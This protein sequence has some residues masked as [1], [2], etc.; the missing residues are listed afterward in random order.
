M[1]K[2]LYHFT[3]LVILAGF[4]AIFVILAEA[5]IFVSTTLLKPEIYSEAMNEKGVTDSIYN[6]LCVYFKSLSNATGIPPEVFTDTL[7]KDELYSTSYKL[8]NECLDY[9]TDKSAPKPKVNYDY[10]ALEDSITNYIA[11]HAEEHGIPKDKEYEKLLNN[12]I[13]IAKAQI[14]ARFDVMMLYKLSGSDFASGIHKYSG[15]FRLGIFIFL[16]I[17]LVLVI[18][19]AVID[20]H[21]PRDYPYWAGLILTVSAGFWLIP[22]IYLKATDYFGSFFIKNAYIHKTVTGLFEISLERMIKLQTI[23]L[24]VGVL[25]IISTL[26]IHTLYVRHLKKNYKKTHS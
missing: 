2:K 13:S 19:M 20:R 24:I 6:E 25:L 23:L 1:K 10:T 9:F 26:V 8:L 3:P 16:G 21:H 11:K 5:C 22:C 4:T 7:D 14:E 15:L 12:T 17:V 18:C